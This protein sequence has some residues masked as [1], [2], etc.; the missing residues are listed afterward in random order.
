MRFSL[1]LVMATVLWSGGVWAQE[2]GCEREVM[3]DTEVLGPLLVAQG[4]T[5]GKDFKALVVEIRDTDRCGYMYRYFD[6]KG[7]SAERDTWWPASAVKLYAA[8]GALSRLREWKFSP[9]AKVTY[10]YSEKDGG[11][12]TVTVEEV[13]K[14]ALIPSD[15]TAFDRLVEIA[16]YEWLNEWILSEEYGVTGTKLLRGYSGRHRYAD[17]GR[18]SLRH[19]PKLTIKEGKKVKEIPEKLSTRTWD[20]KEPGNCTSLLDLAE[21]MRRVILH[22]RIPMIERFPLTGS[23]LKL[24]EESL[25]APRERGNGVVDGLTA[26]FGKDRLT[27][28]HKAGYAREWFSDNVFV[29]DKQTK[30]RWIVVMANRPGRNCLD[31]AAKAMGVILRDGLLG[32]VKE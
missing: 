11:P 15:N 32:E 25:A 2:G 29:I 20:C 17:S 22:K 27:L 19:N 12:V 24:L 10:H 16:G 26:A 4:Y 3:V 8:V 28:Y 13:V 14:A 7:T 1:L 30:R 21:V 6:Y 9:A 5:P 23:E 18:G 31:Q